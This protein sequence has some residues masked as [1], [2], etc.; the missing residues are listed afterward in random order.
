MGGAG[1]HAV[2]PLTPKLGQASAT[3]AG[4]AGK[5]GQADPA[6]LEVTEIEGDRLSTEVGNR[7]R[8]RRPHRVDGGIKAR[9]IFSGVAVKGKRAAAGI[10][11]T[12]ETI[13]LWSRVRRYDARSTSFG[14]GSLS[15]NSVCAHMRMSSRNFS[16]AALS[17]FAVLSIW[18]TVL[19][20]VCVSIGV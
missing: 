10:T 20:N 3:D 9:K 15:S 11:A 17:I 19:I 5:L 18:N 12:T 16:K 2:E 1:R 8:Q 14:S 4:Q 7:H 13:P 6:C